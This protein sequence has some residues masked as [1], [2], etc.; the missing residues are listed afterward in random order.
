MYTSL[1]NHLQESAEA[2]RWANSYDVVWW[3]SFVTRHSALH[4][5][6]FLLSCWTRLWPHWNLWCWNCSGRY[7]VR[8][9]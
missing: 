7:T 3:S 1:Q 6:M 2:A 4:E 8:V 5:Y 9:I